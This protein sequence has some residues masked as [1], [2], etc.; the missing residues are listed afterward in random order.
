MF[1]FYLRFWLTLWYHQTVLFLFYLRF[2]LTLWYLQTVLF[3]FYLRFWL[4][5]WYLQTVLFLFNL[6][7]WLTVWY[8]QT[9]LFLFYL[10]FWLTLWYLQTLLTKRILFV[11]NLFAFNVIKY[12]SFYH[13]DIWSCYCPN[14]VIFL[15][16][17]FISLTSLLWLVKWYDHT[18]S[19]IVYVDEGF[20]FF[21]I[22]T[23][24]DIKLKGD[25]SNNIWWWFFFYIWTNLD[26]ILMGDN[27]NSIW[28]SFSLSELTYEFW[29]SLCKIVRS[30]VIL[31]LPLFDVILKG[32]DNKNICWSAFFI[33]LSWPRRHIK[34]R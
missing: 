9:V 21:Y 23:D 1:L 14:S 7:F 20:F 11:E 24:L 15:F 31:L 26:I 17:F 16:L 22:W 25:N 3:L 4:T 30:S 12:V 28:R 6:R 8:L 5:L 18:V 33:Y 2:W 10:R 19:K 13:F 27:T 34:G 32:D 29:L